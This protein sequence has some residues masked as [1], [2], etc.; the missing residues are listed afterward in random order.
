MS[1]HLGDRKR[2]ESVFDFVLSDFAFDV[3]RTLF[4]IP[5]ENGT[6]AFVY[7]SFRRSQLCV[8]D[9]RGDEKNVKAQYRTEPQSSRIYEITNSRCILEF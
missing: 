9:K 7:V 6:R 4:D 5:L 3:W 2:D 8:Y 1:R